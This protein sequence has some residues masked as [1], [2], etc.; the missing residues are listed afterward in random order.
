MPLF[1]EI[2]AIFA[3]FMGMAIGTPVGVI[4]GWHR[5]QIGRSTLRGAIGGFIGGF[6]F[7][8]VAG[9]FVYTLLPQR[10][11]H[12]EWGT[13]SLPGISEEAL[14]PFFWGATIVGALGGSL[15]TTIST[16]I[17]NDHCTPS[18]AEAIHHGE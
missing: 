11:V 12:T 13:R 2:V 6:L 15:L 8:V 14:L 5:Q 18:D 1:F 9:I 7:F 3:G 17:R 10:T 4:V 16:R